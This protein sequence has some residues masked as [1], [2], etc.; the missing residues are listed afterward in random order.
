MVV[1]FGDSRHSSL[2]RIHHDVQHRLR[3]LRNDTRVNFNA[4]GAVDLYE[5]VR[6]L[7]TAWQ[8]A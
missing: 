1:A 4:G 6:R 7:T 5:R 2:T 3:S 8:R